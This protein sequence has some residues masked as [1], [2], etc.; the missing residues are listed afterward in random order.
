M[1][2]VEAS[3]PM[4]WDLAR[5]S[6]RLRSWFIAHPAGRRWCGRRPRTGPGTGRVP[7]SRQGAGIGVRVRRR[8]ERCVVC[9]GRAAGPAG[10]E[11]ATGSVGRHRPA[12]GTARWR[13]RSRTTIPDDRS[14]GIHS[15]TAYAAIRIQEPQ[16]TVP[17]PIAK[18]GDYPAV[19]QIGHQPMV[20]FHR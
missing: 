8:I 16:P 15:N 12:Q 10:R 3:S 11:L 4:K 2:S 1:G 18:K 6:N 17:H 5:P 9:N 19:L 13:D 14:A 20:V 7:G